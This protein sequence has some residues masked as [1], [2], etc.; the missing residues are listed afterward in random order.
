[1]P[2]GRACGVG[3][4]LYD[5]IEYFIALVLA[6]LLEFLCQA[7]ILEGQDG[8]SV[9]GCILGTVNSRP[10]RAIWFGGT[11]LLWV[12]LHSELC[13]WLPTLLH[14]AAPLVASTSTDSLL[15]LWP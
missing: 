12:A 14:H 9:E 8:Y 10:A 11:T 6:E 1:M 7:F 3:M 2:T 4:M 15:A 5:C 13:L